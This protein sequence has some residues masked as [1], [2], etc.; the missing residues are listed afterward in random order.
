MG[1]I[2]L[3]RKPDGYMEWLQKIWS[4]SIP[5]SKIQSKD[6]SIRSSRTQVGSETYRRYKT[7]NFLMNL[8]SFTWP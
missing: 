8:F 6:L 2:L 7:L 3:S 4:Q 5:V 1:K